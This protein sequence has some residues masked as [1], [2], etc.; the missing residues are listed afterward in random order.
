MGNGPTRSGSFA[1]STKVFPSDH[2]AL[3]KS[4]KI[5]RANI[6]THMLS[7]SLDSSSTALDSHP[8]PPPFTK[9][10]VRGRLPA[11]SC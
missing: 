1:L 2:A 6:I 8:P 11:V 9:V 10:R 4:N 7:M 5:L 3:L